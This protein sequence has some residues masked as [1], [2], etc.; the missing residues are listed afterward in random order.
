MIRALALQLTGLPIDY[1]RTLESVGPASV[2][3][4]RTE[5]GTGQIDLWNDCSHYRALT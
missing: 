3:L 4:V 2:S 1:F 5:N